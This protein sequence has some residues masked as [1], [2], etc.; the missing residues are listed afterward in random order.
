MPGI[1]FYKR[2]GIR[3]PL[4]K[5]LGLGM[6]AYTYNPRYFKGRGGEDCSLRPAGEKSL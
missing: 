6:V 4:L 3:E 5:I 2:A 1:A